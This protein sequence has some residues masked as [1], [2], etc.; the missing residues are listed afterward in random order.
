MQ[1]IYIITQVIA[2]LIHRHSTRLVSLQPYRYTSATSNSSPPCKRSSKKRG[3][4]HNYVKIK[5][6]LHLKTKICSPLY[7]CCG[8]KATHRLPGGNI[9]LDKWEDLVTL[10]E[11]KAVEHISQQEEW[12]CGRANPWGETHDPTYTY[13][14]IQEMWRICLFWLKLLFKLS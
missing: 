8:G 9:L 11:G 1:S 2:P 6:N 3:N 14:Y 13:T 10:V 12:G 7:R 4:K 5:P